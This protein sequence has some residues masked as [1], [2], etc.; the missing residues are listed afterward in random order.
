MKCP[1]RKIAHQALDF[2]FHEL[3]NYVP[4]IQKYQELECSIT[5]SSCLVNVCVYALND[6]SSRKPND[7]I[8]Q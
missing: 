4:G 5:E 7:V 1:R 3:G 8:D 2:K 6:K